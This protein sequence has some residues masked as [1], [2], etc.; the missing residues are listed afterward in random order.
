MLLWPEGTEKGQDVWLSRYDPGAKTWS[1]PG[2]LFNSAEQRR[3]LSA[4]LRPGG[5]IVLGLQSAAVTSETVTFSG[6]VTGSVPVVGATARVL[7]ATIPAG[8]VPA[9]Q[10]A[11]LFMPVVVR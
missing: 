4:T 11:Q 6:G 5:D 2:P 7:L 3:S 10:H 8:Y 9:P 1:Q